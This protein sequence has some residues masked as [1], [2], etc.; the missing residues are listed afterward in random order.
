MC[1][2]KEILDYV[3]VWRKILNYGREGQRSPIVEGREEII[4]SL[5][6]ESDAL[7][8]GMERAIYTILWRVGAIHL[9]PWPYLTTTAHSSNSSP[10]LVQDSYQSLVWD[11]SLSSILKR[12]SK[13][14]MTDKTM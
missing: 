11:R 10:C 7:D 8:S 9:A 14:T 13:S 3:E 1:G 12:T 4:G 5:K 6:L 2:G